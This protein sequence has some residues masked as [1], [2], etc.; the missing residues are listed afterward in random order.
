MELA[1]NFRHSPEGKESY[2]LRAQTIERVFAIFNQKDKRGVGK[3]FSI[4]LL[5]TV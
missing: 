5:S 2:S 1:E 3:V 4:P